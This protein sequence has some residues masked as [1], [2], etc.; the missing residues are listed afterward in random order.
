MLPHPCQQIVL[1]E[2]IHTITE[3]VKRLQR[4]DN[5]LEYQVK[6]WRYY[7]VVKAVQAMRGVRLLVAVGVI[8]ELGDLNRFDHPRK[9][10]SYVGLVPSDTQ[11]EATGDKALSLN[12]VIAEQ[13][14]YWLKVLTPIVMPLIFLLNYKNGKSRSVRK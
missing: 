3:R 4:L 8:A 11:V 14:A 5:E 2:A 7:P 1:Q 13:D 12:V 6:L 10:M 9:L